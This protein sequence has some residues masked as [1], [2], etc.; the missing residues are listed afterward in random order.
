M[1]SQRRAVVSVAAVSAGRG[2][3]H[4]RGGEFQYLHAAHG[5]RAPRARWGPVAV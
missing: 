1:S 4:D 3:H 2:S 5:R